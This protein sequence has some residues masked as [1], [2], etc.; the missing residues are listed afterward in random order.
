M[1]TTTDTPLRPAEQTYPASGLTGTGYGTYFFFPTM[2]IYLIV[3]NK[4]LQQ[5]LVLANI[6]LALVPLGNMERVS[7][8]ITNIT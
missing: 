8:V 6:P 5:H 2:P 7:R 1:K 3:I 4:L